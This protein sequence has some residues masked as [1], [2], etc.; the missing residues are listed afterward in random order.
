MKP[1]M[2]KKEELMASGPAQA[3]DF[4]DT[5]EGEVID[6]QE[7]S[8]L[9]RRLDLRLM[10]LLCI[11]YALQSIDR[12]TL[13][14]AAVFGIREDI[15]LSPGPGPAFPTNVLLQKLPIN[16]FMSAT[17]VL[18]GA[19]LMC[20]AASRG[21]ASIAATRAFLGAF[22]ASINPGTMLLFSM[23][24]SRREQ[25]VRMGVWIGSA[26]LGYI[27]AGIV[28]FGIGHIRGP[29]ASWR[30]LFLFWGA[31]TVAWGV[32]MLVFL[33]G[34]PLTT[35][36]LS[37]RERALVVGRVKAN[38]TG[39]ENKKFKWPQFKE[40]MTDLK[41][42]L[43]FLFAV[44][45]NSPNGGL[46]TFQGLVIRG[47][48]F[49]TL[50]TTLIQMPSERSFFASY[51]PNARI[52]IMLMCLAPFLA[53]I[54]GLWLIDQSNPYGR[55]A[56]LWI[57]FA[58]TATWTL[59]MSVA[60]ANTAGHTKK[61]TTNAMLLIGYCLGNFVGPFFFRAEQAPRYPLG[62][63]MMLFCVG[64]Q[65]A[66]LCGLWS[67]LWLRNRSR[68]AE[69]AGSRENEQQAYERGLLDET[70]LQNKYFKY[71]Y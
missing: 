48:G 52:A 71:V 39:V 2:T 24:Y 7:S 50:Q 25:P 33:P 49:S 43:L 60:T 26:G 16:H 13:S 15:G 44:A 70:D 6:P 19:V 14:Y 22:E 54:L 69:H 4:L 28:T 32:L 31:V 40:A 42:W 38:G 3:L 21:F 27:V 37:E 41:T 18:W 61:I 9:L 51:Y 20:H 10:P 17:V 45:S 56:C 34:S 5:S 62:V 11:T 29:V 12:T 66:C 57:S 36:F 63:A 47:M 1:D 8:A 67:L 23:Y 59:S 55:L 35:K 58:Y 30:I 46:T 65:I 68:T 53:G 64:V